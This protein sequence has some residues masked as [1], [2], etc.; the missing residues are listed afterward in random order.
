MRPILG[1][2]AESIYDIR[3]PCY[4][5]FKVDG[6]RAIWQGLEFISRSGKTIPNRALRELAAQNVVPV[7]WDGEII[8]GEPNDPHVFSKTDKFCKT[9]AKSITEPVRLFVFDDQLHLGPFCDRSQSLYDLLPFVVRLDQ[10]L[11]ETYEQLAELEEQAI[12]SGY[13]GL[14]TRSPRGPYKQGRSTLREQYLVK[15]KRYIDGEFKIIGFNEMLHN[16]NEAFKNELGYT[17]RSSH[18]E[19]KI[20]T[21][22]L[23][24]IVVDWNGHRLSVG[25]GFDEDQRREIW[26]NQDKYVGSPATIRYL[27]SVKDLPRQPVFKAIRADL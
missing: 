13:E 16:A 4:V 3:L 23:G 19:N 2:R 5:S 26:L 14:V 9:A 27:P 17:K 20:P 6:W 24:S 25:T 15:L 7:G 11:V 8:V 12:S 21:G 18:K 10:T 22:T 1:A